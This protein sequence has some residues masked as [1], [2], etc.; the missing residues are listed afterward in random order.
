MLDLSVLNPQQREAVETLDGPV[1]VLAGAGTGKTRVIT[2]RIAH[3]IAR[4]V[5]PDRILAVTFT[6]KAAREM[7]ERVNELL[8][9]RRA[10]RGGRETAR[11]ARPLL[12]TFH[13]FGV[14]LLR[15][16]IE[17]LGYKRNFVIYSESDQLALVRRILG[18]FSGTGPA[19]DPA[20]VLAWLSRWRN[21]DG[22]VPDRLGEETRPL[23]ERVR[24]AYEAGLRACNAVDFDDLLLLPLRLFREQPDV[25]AECQEQYRY[26]LVDEYQDTNAVQFELLRLLAGRHRNLCVVGD[27]DQSIYGWRGAE[28]SNLLDLEQHFPGLRVIRLEQNYRSTNT[29]LRAANALIRNN[30][31]RRPKQLWSR[32]GEG[33][34]IKVRVFANEE[35]EA[36]GVVEEIEARR[37]GRRIPWSA[38][39][40]LFRTNTQARPLETALRRA[41]VRYRVVGGQSFFDRRE[42]KDVVAW[43]KT[44]VNPEDDISLLRIANVPPRGLGEETMER[45]L[46]RSVERH[47]SV[48]AVLQEAV[49]DESLPGRTRQAVQG[50]VGLIEGARAEL[51]GLDGAELPEWLQGFLDRLGY[52]ALVRRTEKDAEAGENRVRNVKEFLAALGEPENSGNGA[53][54]TSVERLQRFLEEVS[55]DAERQEED[56]AASAGDAV[57]LITM[58]S[59]KGLEFPHVFIVGLEE[60]L[61]PHSRSVAEGSIEEERRLFY[62]AVT[63]AM[64]TLHLSHCSARRKYGEWTP[65]HPSRFLRE[66]PTELLETESGRSKPV[67]AAAARDWFARMREAVG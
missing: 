7:L 13:S 49:S 20:A 29:I 28:L 65:C 56:E 11:D 61:L 36:A 60:G 6:N 58:H 18:R 62:V 24:A 47:C 46:A 59:C 2:Y 39:A 31:R 37:L 38:H 9:A 43:M 45:L 51:A 57:T 3:L 35:E 19:V 16:Y 8:K 4:G 64:E 41:G 14:R 5:P 25:L 66:L 34:K 32:K 53:P 1:L 48:Y 40:I 55:L 67:D 50:L 21:G 23:A 17:R 27:D 54:E 12:C 42:I 63:R 30:A 15:R 44:L 52:F 33:S 10:G 22:S 26:V